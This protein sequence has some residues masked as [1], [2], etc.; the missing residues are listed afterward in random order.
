M[1]VRTVQTANFVFRCPATD[2]DVQHELGDD[3][4][5]SENEYEAVT[6]VACAALHLVNR[7]TGKVMGQ[8]AN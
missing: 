6:C 8:A 4:D 1:S 3:P 2:F 7:R 5:I